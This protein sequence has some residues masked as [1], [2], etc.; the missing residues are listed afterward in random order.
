MDRSSPYRRLGS[1]PV[2]RSPLVGREREL[3]LLHALLRRDDIPLLTLTG[4]GGIGKTRLAIEVAR[5]MSGDVADGILFVS[6]ASVSRSVDVL[7]LIAEVAGVREAGDRSVEEGLER[8]LAGKR[9]LIVLDNVEQVA[10]AGADI[11]PLLVRNSGLKMIVTSRVPLHVSG[12]QEF[13]VPALR[14]PTP[15]MRAPEELALNPAVALFMQRAQAVKPEMKLDA[16]NAE[17]I[18][19]V[20]RSLDGLPLAIELAAAR[21]KILAPSALLA[22]LTHALRILTG[23]PRDQPARLRTMRDAIAWSYHLLREEEQALFRN[24]SVFVGGGSIEAAEAISADFGDPGTDGLESLTILADNSMVQIGE[25]VGGEP[26]FTLLQTTREF[27]LEQLVE[28][29]ET[30]AARR[31]HAAWCLRL[32]EDAWHVFAS[33]ADQGTWLDRMESA[34]GNLRAALEWLDEAGDIES[35]LLLSGR[36]AWFW[37]VRGH[38]VEGRQWLE[39]ALDRGVEAPPEAR[40]PALLGLAILTHWQGDDVRASSCLEEC[41]ALSQTIEDPWLTAYTTFMLGVVA[42]DTGDFA[43]AVPLQEDAHR[44]FQAMGDRANAALSMTHLGIVA[45]GAGDLDTAIPRLEAA[46][47]VQREVD[48]TWA[49][50]VSLSYLGFAACDRQQFD[51]AAGYFTESLVMRWA[52]RTQEEVAHGIA[53]FATLAAALGQHRRAARLFGAA[54]AEREAIHLMLQEPERSRYAQA[55]DDTRRHLSRDAFAAAWDEGRRLAPEQAVAE[56]LAQLPEPRIS[57]TLDDRLTPREREV[58]ALLVQG[59][60]DREIAETLFL[61]VRTAHG[62][63]ANILAKLEVHTRTAAAAAAIAAGVNTSRPSAP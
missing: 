55:V 27:G 60:T 1:L 12:E 38:L 51:R 43:R 20:C 8:F 45:W 3:T 39:R 41:L 35:A 6:A 30:E 33:R 58:L 18:A 34:H 26:R 10:D 29:G 61:S 36:L 50:S 9:L 52:M 63:V 13:E 40:A 42:E 19:E 22:R 44:R 16:D 28:H 24:L 23:G 57:T 48:D 59:K 14:L 37:Y 54:E 32:T 5:E 47:Q 31:R 62:H 46:L 4:P 21:S 7:P 56:A 2:T 49:A 17:A 53:N 11:A 25:G 15:E